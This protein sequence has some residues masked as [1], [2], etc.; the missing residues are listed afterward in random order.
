MERCARDILV[1]FFPVCHWRVCEVSMALS[2][3]LPCRDVTVNL[4]SRDD[5]PFHP[6]SSISASSTMC[7]PVSDC[8]VLVGLE[9][10]SAH[11]LFALGLGASTNK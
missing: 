8:E 2:L 1:N 4:R 5:V 10:T 11:V 9:A 6:A 3:N 7:M